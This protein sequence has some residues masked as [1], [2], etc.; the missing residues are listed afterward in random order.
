V[1]RVSKVL[2]TAERHKRHMK[3]KLKNAERIQTLSV[4]NLLIS[5]KN[6]YASFE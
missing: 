4:K 2:F 5:A 3:G 1:I 6:A